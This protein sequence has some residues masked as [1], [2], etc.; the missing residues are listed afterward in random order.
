MPTLLWEPP[1][2]LVERA[3]M[4]RYMRE[5]GFERYADLWQWSV[6]DVDGFW[7]SIW[8]FFGVA[9]SYDR[10]LASRAMPG[11]QWFPGAEVNYA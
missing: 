4:T 11:A 8:D 7:A 3:V 10:V 5:R 6:H 1:A 2:E 9:G